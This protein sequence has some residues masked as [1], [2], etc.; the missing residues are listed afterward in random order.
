M[1]GLIAPLVSPGT[2]I[3]LPAARLRRRYHRGPR[4]RVPHH[5]R[6]ILGRGTAAFPASLNLTATP[7]DGS[8]QQA[9]KGAGNR[10]ALTSRSSPRDTGTLRTHATDHAVE[11]PM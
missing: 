9:G 1:Y 10:S 5:P 6:V 3:H 8:H 7:E 2:K 11:R 4:D